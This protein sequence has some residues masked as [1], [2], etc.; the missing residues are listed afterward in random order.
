MCQSRP[1]SRPIVRVIIG[2]FGFVWGLTS[3]AIYYRSGAPVPDVLRDL[4]I[5][6]IYLYGGLAI[7]SSRPAN[8]TGR[9]MTLVG[10]TW[11][12]GNL[13]L[14]EAPVVHEIGVAFADVVF[15]C[16]IA[17]ILAYPT[18]RLETR[19]DR[20]TVVILAIGTTIN[21]SVRLIPLQAGIDLEPARLYVGLSLAI[22]AY[23]VVLRRWFAAP[24]RR[25]S[26]L[27]PVLIAGSVLMAVLAT[28]LALQIL[29]MPAEIQALLLAARGLAPAAIPLAL[30][31]GFYRQSE[32]RQRALLDAMPDLMIRFTTAGN[33]IDIRTDDAALLRAPVD[34]VAGGRIE[35]VLPPGIGAALI[36]A[37][38]AA[39]NTGNIQTLDFS[40]DLPSGR[41]DYEARLT[42][43]GADEV[44]AVVRDFTEQRAAQ[45][46]LRESRARIVEAT[47]A[48]RR[49]LERDLHD[50]AQQRLVAV[51]LALRLARTRLSPDVDTMAL[52]GLNDAGEELKT[53]L[54]EL[55]ELARGIHPAILTEA[56]LGPAIDSLAARSAVPAEV[57]AVPTRRLSPAVESTAY[58]VVS[59][60]LANVAKYASATR[61]TVSAECPGDSLRV[62]VTDDGVGGADPTRGSGL[63][64]LADRVAAINGSLS[65]DSP[66]GGGTRLVAELP[67]AD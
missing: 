3:E 43:S 54:T 51:S 30:L 18:G 31:V 60:A 7:W 35:D 66:M 41:H 21:N 61:A 1:V 27:L 23:V 32:L 58:F 46:E 49:R 25:R 33:Y 65:I 55:R 2:V 12:I 38:S 29:Q 44:T 24:A 22:L 50:G 52:V 48:E 14:S 57:I 28:N 36:A 6:W 64:G 5:G 47:V 13:Q 37:G 11:F 40:V 34:S 10:L 42:P 39:I 67:L 20:Y 15:V 16:L 4:S 45:K 8:R 19:L 53:A 63:R 56:G 17:L 26:E 62:E 9:L 59:E